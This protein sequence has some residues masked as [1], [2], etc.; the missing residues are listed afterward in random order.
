MRQSP[1]KIRSGHWCWG[2]PNFTVRSLLDPGAKRSYAGRRIW[3]GKVPESA[4]SSEFLKAFD[5]RT[6]TRNVQGGGPVVGLVYIFPYTF[7]GRNLTKNLSHTQVYN[8]RHEQR[9]RRR[10]SP[11]EL[12]LAL[13][14]PIPFSRPRRANDRLFEQ[15][16]SLLTPLPFRRTSRLGPARMN[17]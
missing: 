5:A 12:A 15:T 2:G 8:A 6:P 16:P 13:Q 1:R 11:R 17:V 3:R 4:V 9:P 14:L 7:A 10:I